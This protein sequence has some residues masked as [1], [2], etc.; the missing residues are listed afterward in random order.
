MARNAPALAVRSQSAGAASPKKEY[1]EVNATGS[2]F[3]EG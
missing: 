3:H 1:S 2:G